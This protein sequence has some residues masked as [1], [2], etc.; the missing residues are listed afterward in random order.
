MKPPIVYEV[1]RPNPH[2]TM[3]RTA[4]VQSM[5]ASLS[6]SGSSKQRAAGGAA[7]FVVPRARCRLSVRM[8]RVSDSTAQTLP[9]RG[10]RFRREALVRPMLLSR[11]KVHS[12]EFRKEER[13]GSRVSGR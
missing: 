4:T 9:H 12:H 5:I 8:L 2:R 1:T 13:A 10:Q 11:E 7:A 6:D 3:R